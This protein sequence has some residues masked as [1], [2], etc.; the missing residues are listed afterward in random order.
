MHSVIERRICNCDVFVLRD[1]IVAMQAARS[2]PFRYEVSEVTF[3]EP[4]ALS[5][6]YIRSIRPGKRAGDPTV[7]D[8]HVCAYQYTATDGNAQISNKLYWDDNW[9]HLP[10][11]L[12]P[13][14]KFW[15]QMN[16]ERLPITTSKYNDLQ[17]MKP[18]MPQSV[19]HFYDN[20]PHK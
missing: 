18:V 3:S 14:R 9:K 8:V 5:G 20:L 15:Q 7:S 19:H 2:S 12:S 4:Q 1:Y 11:R 16:V 13:Q 10:E 6:E 17:A